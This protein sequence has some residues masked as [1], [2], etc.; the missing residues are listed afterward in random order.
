[1]AVSCLAKAAAAPDHCKR[2][3]EQENHHGCFSQNKLSH[4]SAYCGPLGREFL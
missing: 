1:M 4:L 3:A 2:Q